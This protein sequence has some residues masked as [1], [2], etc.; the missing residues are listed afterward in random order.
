MD[1]SSASEP[2]SDRRFAEALKHSSSSVILASFRQRGREGSGQKAFYVNRPLPMFARSAW[3]GVVNV[4]AD[5]DALFRHYSYGDMIDGEFVPSMGALLAGTDKASPGDFRIDFG[6]KADRVPRVS[7]ID[8]L[9][10]TPEALE[11][12]R[13][14]KII[15][16]GTAL[17]LGDRLNVPN[18]RILPGSLLQILAAESLLQDRAISITS[19]WTSLALI[20]LCALVTLLIRNRFHL[21]HRFLFLVG[22]AILCEAAAIVL[23]SILPI[24]VDTSYL[25]IAVVAYLIA[26]A[27]NEIQ[28]RGLLRSIAEHRF[29][30]VAMS[31]ADGFVCIDQH[32]NVTFANSAVEA[33]FGYE[34]TEIL[35]KPWQELLAEAERDHAQRRMR[36]SMPR[37][38]LEIEPTASALEVTGL[39]KDGS[40]F[41]LECSLSAWKDVSGISY[42][43]VLRDITDRKEHEKRLLY[44]ATHDTLTGLANRT[45]LVAMLETL[46]SKQEANN[47]EIALILLAFPRL[48]DL[49]EIYGL[50][51]ADEALCVVARTLVLS[52]P[53]AA[54]VA[55]IG[56]H[57]F[58]V[59]M[60]TG[61]DQAMTVANAL[62]AG[63]QQEA[64][65]IGD[66]SLR[67]SPSIGV[68]VTPR[69]GMAVEE[70]MGNAHLA[71]S[72]SSL[73]TAHEPA[74]FAPHMRQS[75]ET[76]HRLEAE[77][78]IAIAENQ[79]EL[80]YQPQVD[81]KTGALVGAEALIRWR[82]PQKG[83]VAPGIFMPFVNNSAMSEPVSSWVMRNAMV[84]AAVWE[85]LGHRVRMG[86]NL[87]PSQFNG[88]LAHQV[89]SLLM[90]TGLDPRLLE[91]EITEDIMLVNVDA[92]RQMLTQI[93]AHGVK[94]ALDDFGTG[95]GNL[96]YLKTYPVDT[97]KIDQSFVRSLMQDGNDAPIVAA[98]VM[99][100]RAL[101]LG[102]I[103]EGIEDEETAL[104]L[105][106]LGC[107]EGQG[108]LYGKPMP[109]AE[110]ERRYLAS[111]LPLALCS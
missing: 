30:K 54:T 2:E 34:S 46:A 53:K 97:M 83:Y 60:P 10:E 23:Q 76:N 15:V 92:A 89:T 110:F 64:I 3:P 103:A 96:S 88:N 5:H 75:I 52:V 106:E 95:Y 38:K 21:L 35:G 51:F 47:P 57:E 40:R 80:F 28:I 33:I 93:R 13:G 37:Q 101:S 4:L 90:E 25:H 39:R 84:Q 77:L 45:N 6:I 17:E 102:L 105:R 58:A 8:I 100:G 41:D 59:L 31:L 86:I 99:L 108:Y 74:I 22:G 19:K 32:G 68:D 82:H 67:F 56:D 65:I 20:A 85:R 24:A 9:N 111:A 62:H 81:L 72:Q 109:A 7:Y 26:T 70:F 14:R 12:I 61:I 36:A 107:V 29:R 78:R 94:I 69:V 42:G 16:S 104:R 27:L 66:R 1:F 55:R 43:A 79:F 91:L 49:G 63:F 71:L 44:L 73:V 98:T 11:E 50:N 87:S 48:Q 18:G